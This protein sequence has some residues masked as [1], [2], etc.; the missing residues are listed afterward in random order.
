MTL[1]LFSDPC[2]KRNLGALF[3]EL[4]CDALDPGFYYYVPDLGMVLFCDVAY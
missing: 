1:N 4:K 3:F 2:S